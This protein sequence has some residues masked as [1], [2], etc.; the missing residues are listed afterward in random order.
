MKALSIFLISIFIGSSLITA[1]SNEIFLNGG[2]SSPNKPESLADHWKTGFNVG[3][4]IGFG[5]TETLTFV[6]SADYNSFAF[7]ESGFLES[8]GFSGYGIR[9]TGGTATIFTLSGNLKVT[10]ASGSIS[11][12]VV[13][14]LGYLNLAL[15]D[16]TISLGNESDKVSGDSESSLFVQVGVG[17]DFPLS[18]NSS[19][20]FEGRYGNGFT[21][22]GGT[23]FF[24]LK[25]GIK[26]N[27]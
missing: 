5:L 27:L 9:I 1:Q 20:F 23:T 21:D 24:P 14:G 25:A 10:F 11:P 7:D 13:G 16:I 8:Y 2:I 19:L 22:N 26:F 12:Y 3:G 4:G 18:E 6:A 17:L 15:S